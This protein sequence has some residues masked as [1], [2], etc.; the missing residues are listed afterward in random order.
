MKNFL[1]RISIIALTSVNIYTGPAYEYFS[2]DVRA[3]PFEFRIP[4][5]EEKSYEEYR[6]TFLMQLPLAPF[7]ILLFIIME[8]W[9]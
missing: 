5:T 9:T 2:K 7:A 6:A 3:T 1:I 8:V 4:F